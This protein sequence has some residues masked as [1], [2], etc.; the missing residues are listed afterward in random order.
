[1]SSTRAYHIAVVGT[2]GR[3]ESFI[4]VERWSRVRLEILRLVDSGF[5]Q[6]RHKGDRIYGLSQ[7][8]DAGTD[9]IALRDHACGRGQRNRVDPVVV[10]ILVNDLSVQREPAPLRTSDYLNRD[11]SIHAPLISAEY[12]PEQTNIKA[13]GEWNQSHQ[14][15]GDDGPK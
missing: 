8:M 15:C 1:M 5:S 13:F 4:F 10:A 3:I 12:V 2:L 6:L 7:E 11:E 14:D 9:G